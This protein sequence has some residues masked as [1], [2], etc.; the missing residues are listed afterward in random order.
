VQRGAHVKENDFQKAVA[1]PPCSEASCNYTL[2]SC[3]FY[4]SVHSSQTAPGADQLPHNSLA[5]SFHL[6]GAHRD[7]THLCF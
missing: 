5:P 3:N 1:L 6:E 4:C 7:G 2:L